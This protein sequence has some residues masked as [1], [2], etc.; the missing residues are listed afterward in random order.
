[1]T[2]RE[3]ESKTVNNRESCASNK[4]EKEKIERQNVTHAHELSSLRFGYHIV[5]MAWII[6]FA[7]KISFFDKTKLGI[8]VFVNCFLSEYLISISI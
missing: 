8:H 4:K 2:K 1:M 7:T 6:Y 5:L 3:N